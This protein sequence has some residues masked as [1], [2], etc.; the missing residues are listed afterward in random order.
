MSGL[1]LLKLSCGRNIGLCVLQDSSSKLGDPNTQS[2]Y[3][4]IKICSSIPINAPILKA[5]TAYFHSNMIAA[6]T[7]TS[8][9]A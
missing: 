9:K 8:E 1:Y 5:N 4:I 7:P 6:P 2:L 3:F